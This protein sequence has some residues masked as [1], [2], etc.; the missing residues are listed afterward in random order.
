MAEEIVVYDTTYIRILI[1]Y[2]FI[3]IRVG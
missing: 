3:Q 2:I 1:I